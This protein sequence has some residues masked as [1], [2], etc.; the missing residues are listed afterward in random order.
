VVVP[1]CARSGKRSIEG[2][3]EHGVARWGIRPARANAG[4]ESSP[5]RGVGAA[6]RITPPPQ[7]SVAAAAARTKEE[8]QDQESALQA[9]EVLPA[10]PPNPFFCGDCGGK[11]ALLS[12]STRVR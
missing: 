2:A 7:V 3:A 5:I 6:S 8:E 11:G 4:C 1:V 10:R 9:R 12:E